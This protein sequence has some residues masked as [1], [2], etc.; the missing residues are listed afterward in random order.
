MDWT[1][2]ESALFAA[3]RDAYPSREDLEI[4]LG[5]GLEKSL[6][7]IAT[8][9]S[10]KSIIF[11]LV[12]SAKSEGW[13]DNLVEAVLADRPDNMLLG[14]WAHNYRQV[15]LLRSDPADGAAVA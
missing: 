1:Q 5:E 3:L 7:D 14:M 6:E 11:R 10:L 15:D 8:S 9:G 12:R 2:R 13:L 4:V